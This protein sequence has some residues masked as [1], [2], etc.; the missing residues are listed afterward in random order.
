MKTHRGTTK[1][2]QAPSE[3]QMAPGNGTPSRWRDGNQ[4]DDD[5][6]LE[7]IMRLAQLRAR[8]KPVLTE[9]AVQTFLDRLRGALRP[10][11]N[12]NGR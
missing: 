6:I 12:G 4:I 1:P 9:Q 8:L 11:R 5:S 10:A 2:C 7:G 3:G